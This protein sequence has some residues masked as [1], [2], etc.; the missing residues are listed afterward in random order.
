MGFR[1]TSEQ[2]NDKILAICDGIERKDG[3]DTLTDYPFEPVTGTGKCIWYWGWY[4]REV[5]FDRNRYTLNTDYSGQN[6]G[7]CE[8]N[9]WGYPGYSLSIEQSL[10][11]REALERA[12]DNPSS[13][14]LATVWRVMQGT[15]PHDLMQHLRADDWYVGA[16]NE[17]TLQPLV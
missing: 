16:G 6:A 5:N 1:Y 8:S 12:V 2:L 13:D 3:H 7:F 14:N 11:I 10:E 15:I 9:K 17:R 4:W